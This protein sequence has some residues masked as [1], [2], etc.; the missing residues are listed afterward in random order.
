MKNNIAIVVVLVVLA[1][2]GIWYVSKSAPLPSPVEEA[3]QVSPSPEA[4]TTAVMEK[5]N[6]TATDS[7]AKEV[8]VE[9]LE[10]KFVA[11]TLTVKKGEK[12]KLTFK[13]TGKMPHDWV[14][15][16]L[17]IRTKV[18][19]SGTTEVIEF[20]PDKAGVFEYYCSVGKHRENGMV[21]KITVTE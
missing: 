2:G 4:S 10:F 9:G 12:V 14:V 5:S 6:T 15:D 3:S 8:T 17:G 20:T 21:G 7:T 1:A 19:S 11:D 13:N 16:E 18:I